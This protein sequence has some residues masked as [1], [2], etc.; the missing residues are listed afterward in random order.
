MVIIWA[1]GSIQQPS[2]NILLRAVAYDT[3]QKQNFLPL[4]EMKR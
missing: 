1:K 3:V 4:Q 2:R